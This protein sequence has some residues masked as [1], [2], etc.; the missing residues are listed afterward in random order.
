VL[1]LTFVVAHALRARKIMSSTKFTLRAGEDRANLRWTMAAESIDVFADAVHISVM[2][3]GC[4]L[5]FGLSRP[6]PMGGSPEL[7]ESAQL[8]SDRLATV[9]M[10]PE[11]LKA[12]AFLLREHVL[13]YEKTA[14][15]RIDLPPDLMRPA[16]LGSSLERWN[17]CWEY[18][19]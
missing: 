3:F 19:E 16:L 10:T 12:F 1:G 5:Q 4:T 2:A 14:N 7:T 17:N 11:L 6:V 18:T 9:R 8:P 13:N 15:L